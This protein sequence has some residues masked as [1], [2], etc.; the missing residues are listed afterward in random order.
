MKE[1]E[2]IIIGWLLWHFYQVP[3]FLVS[4]WKN[5]IFFV[6]DFFSAPLLLKS[7]FSPW[8]KTAWRYPKGFIITEYLSTFISNIF[9]RI[10][11]AICRVFL[12]ILSLFALAFVLIIGF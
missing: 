8:R 10:I 7:L 12:I 1:K 3:G 5:Y 4:V 6:L 2:N 9:S 11:G